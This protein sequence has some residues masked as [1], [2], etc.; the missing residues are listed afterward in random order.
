M[1]GVHEFAARPLVL[2]EDLSPPAVEAFLKVRGW[3]QVRHQEGLFSIWESVAQDASVMLP[4][5]SSYRDFKARLQDA[6]YTIADVY[7]IK[8]SEDLALE[9]ASAR[10]DILL[11]RADQETVDGSIPLDEAQDLLAGIKLMLTAAACSAIRP[12]ASNRGRRPSAVK[13]FISQ[14]VRMGHTMR[15][16]FVLT[17][18]ARHDGSRTEE[19]PPTNGAD[20]VSAPESSDESTAQLKRLTLPK[21]SAEQSGLGTYTRRVMTTLASGLE[22]ACELLA[23]SSEVGL[24]DAILRGASEELIRSLGQM[25]LQPGLRALDMSFRWSPIQ[26]RPN[27]SSRVILPRPNPERIERVLQ[28]LRKRPVVEQDDLLGHVIRL[29]RPE[30]QHV[31]VVV[32][33]GYLGRTRRRVKMRLSGQD[34][35]TAIRAHEEQR[36]ILARGTVT[37]EDRSWWLTGPVTVRLPLE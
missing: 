4:Y 35:R 24:D 14:E 17:I 21:P 23:D 30:G 13:E 7:N 12:R 33:D 29:E 1:N 26:P 25:T 15:G 6:L 5:D 37:L 34:Y 22:A 27:V 11:L 28:D 20:D 32:V 18:L 10:S 36:A 2:T 16:S 31:G 8:N 9:I 3:Q 19:L